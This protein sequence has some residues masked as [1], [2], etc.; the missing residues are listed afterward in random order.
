VDIHCKR[1]GS[2]L[3]IY[4][5]GNQ[6]VSVQPEQVTNDQQAVGECVSAAVAIDVEYRPD[7]VEMVFDQ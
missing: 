2:G 6:R 7:G 4:C 5:P 1:S 3:Q